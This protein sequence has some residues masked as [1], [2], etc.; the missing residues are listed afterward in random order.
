MTFGRNS[1][2]GRVPVERSTSQN[3]AWMSDLQ[4]FCLVICFHIDRRADH[5]V[6]N[7]LVRVVSGLVE[8]RQ[9]DEPSIVNRDFILT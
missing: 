6:Q 5:S 9:R 7:M 8:K 3:S 1:R 2:L 4:V